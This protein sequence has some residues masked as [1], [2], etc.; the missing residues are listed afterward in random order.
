MLLFNF[1]FFFFFMVVCLTQHKLKIYG[2]SINDLRQWDRHFSY[3]AFILFKSSCTKINFK[4]QLVNMLQ[5]QCKINLHS[6]RPLKEDQQQPPKFCVKDFIYKGE[7]KQ[8]FGVV[9]NLPAQ[10][11]GSFSKNIAI[12]IKVCFGSNRN[13]FSNIKIKCNYNFFLRVMRS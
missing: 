4:T 5:R 3:N 11:V 6:S 9:I 7:C 8:I 2:K 10:D 1:F 12:I 13:W